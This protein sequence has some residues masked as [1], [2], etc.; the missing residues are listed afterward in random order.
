MCAVG[1]WSRV[2]CLH[3]VLRKLSV[4]IVPPDRQCMQGPASM[5]LAKMI[6]G[7]MGLV[8]RSWCARMLM[9]RLR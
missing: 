3:S 6:P 1:L 8:C 7:S 5:S 2:L 4:G 9:A